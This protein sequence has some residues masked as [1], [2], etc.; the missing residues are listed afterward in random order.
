MKGQSFNKRLG[1]A[2]QGLHLAFCREQSLRFHALAVIC[3]LV[4]LFCSPNLLRCG[5]H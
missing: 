3:V 2:L 1:F 5:G 4:V